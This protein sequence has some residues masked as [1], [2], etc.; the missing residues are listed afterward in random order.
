MLFSPLSEIGSIGRNPPYV[1]SFLLFLLI[2]ILLGAVGDKSFAGHIV[3]RFLQGFFGSP[4]LASGGA[5]L[6]DI[7]ERNAVPYAIIPWIGSMYCGPALGPLLSVFAVPHNWKWPLWEIVLLSA[8][9]LLLTLP[10][11]PETAAHKI[12]HRRAQ[13]LRTQTGNPN[14]RAKT[15]LYKLDTAT[16]L[17]D[18][19]I[20]P[21]EIACLDPAMGFA[22]VYVALLYATYYSFFEAFAIVYIGMYRFTLGSFGLVFLCVIVGCVVFAAMYALYLYYFLLNDSRKG[23]RTQE[24]WLK[25]ALP[26]VVLMPASL[27]MFAWTARPDIHWIVPT[28]GIAIYAGASFVIV[29]PAT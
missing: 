24:A 11:L 22:C 26:A 6:D 27:F 10:L 8:P 19:L 25:P 5:S 23:L 28:I 2:S 14:Y 7:Y 3:M 12:L 4:I 1:I 18:A 16:I 29:R 13:H 20:K 15:E 9:V 21:L 17:V